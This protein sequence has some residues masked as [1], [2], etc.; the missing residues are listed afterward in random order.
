M[1]VFSQQNDGLL[2][3][4]ANVTADGLVAND[5]AFNGVLVA[6]PSF[7]LRRSALSGNGVAAVYSRGRDFRCLSNV[8]SGNQGFGVLLTFASPAALL[9]NNVIGLNAAGS[10]AWPNRNN[11]VQIEGDGALFV[12][13]TISGNGIHGLYVIGDN[14][15]LQRNIIGLDATGLRAIP[16]QMQGVYSLG[17]RTV[18]LSNIVAGNGVRGVLLSGPDAEISRS[19]IG[20]AFSG[21]VAVPNGAEGLVI[22]AANVTVNGSVISGNGDA[23]IFI[24]P[25]GINASIANCF[26]GLAA[27]TSVAL[28]NARRRADPRQSCHVAGQ[29]YCKQSWGRRVG[30][31]AQLPRVS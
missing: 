3:A 15:T 11:G 28:P 13:N 4:G 29:R 30:G 8:I 2:I 9:A 6:A 18:L 10:A 7:E 17:K 21:V 12:S 1:R 27:N 5:N 16:N 20:V 26:I 22:D 23:G 24:T 25:R 31:L 14:N 19:L